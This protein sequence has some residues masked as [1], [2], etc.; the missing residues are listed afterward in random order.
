MCSRFNDSRMLS[1]GDENLDKFF[2]ARP[3]LDHLKQ[4]LFSLLCFGAW[5][6]AVP[7]TFDLTGRGIYCL[8]SM[9]QNLLQ[10]CSLASVKELKEI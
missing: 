5:L 9:C 8:G 7:L 6:F 3:I 1:P 10:G 4:K 2:H